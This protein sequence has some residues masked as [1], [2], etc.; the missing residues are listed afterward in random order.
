MINFYTIF[1][2]RKKGILEFFQIVFNESLEI[3]AISSNQLVDHN[4]H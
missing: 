3:L 2:R 4:N 1:Y